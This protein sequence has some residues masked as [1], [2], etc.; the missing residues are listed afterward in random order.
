MFLSNMSDVIARWKN[1]SRI[2]LM[3][4]F[5]NQMLSSNICNAKR[6]LVLHYNAGKRLLTKKRDLKGYGT[7]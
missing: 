7:I 5:S 4:M 3:D 1:R 6:N 2:L